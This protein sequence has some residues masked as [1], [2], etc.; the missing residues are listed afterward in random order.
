MFSIHTSG[1]AFGALSKLAQHGRDAIMRVTLKAAHEVQAKAKINVHQK[2]NTTG[3]AKGT[4]SRS[5]TVLS[6]RNKLQAEIG[7]SVIYG[8]IHEFGGVIKPVKGEYLWFRLPGAQAIS[9]SKSGSVK[10]GATAE[11]HLIRVKQV[12]IPARPYLQPAL[13]E[14]EPKIEG[15]INAEVLGML[16]GPDGNIPFPKVSN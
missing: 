11:G 16:G 7:P 14:I 2:L 5:V 4:L 8:R 1:N 6:N 9:Y 12:T 10:A 3:K 13:D 15:M